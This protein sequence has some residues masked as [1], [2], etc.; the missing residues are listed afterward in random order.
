MEDLKYVVRLITEQMSYID[1][2]CPEK[3][4]QQ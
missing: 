2:E 4:P 3:N 1:I